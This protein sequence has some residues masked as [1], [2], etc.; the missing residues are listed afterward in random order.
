MPDFKKGNDGFEVKDS[1]NKRYLFKILSKIVTAPLTLIVQSIMPR[2]LGPEL[3][4]KYIFQTNIFQQVINFFD[5][6][7]SLAFYTGLSKNLNDKGIIRFYG[8]YT[9]FATLIVLILTSVI[10]LLNQ[11]QNVFPGQEVEYIFMAIFFTVITWWS[12]IIYKI[13]DAYGLT[14]NGEKILIYQKVVSVIFLIIIYHYDLITLTNIFI[15]NYI[16]LFILISW[17]TWCLHKNKVFIFKIPK[18]E[19][20]EKKNKLN[21]FW[22]YSSPLLVF[23]FLGMIVAFFDN[24]FLMKIA[25]PVQQGFFGL[26]FKLSS[27]SF[28]FTGAMTQL[29]TREFSIAHGNNDK[30]QLAIL[31][32]KYIPLLYLVTT[33]L[34][35]FF[36]VYAELLTKW[37][38]G[39]AFINGVL[40]I[41]IMLFYPIHQTYGQLSGSLFYS[42]GQTKLYRNIGIFMLPVGVVGTWITLAPS[43]NFGFHLGALGLALKTI[44][45]QFIAVNVQLYFN[46]KYLGLSFLKFFWHQ[47]YVL[48]TFLFFAFISKILLSLL[49]KS[50]IISFALSSIIYVLFVLI[51]LYL[52]PESISVTKAKRNDLI[53]NFQNLLINYKIK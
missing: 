17:W 49:I 24:W 23:S 13:I 53:N 15:Y 14:T 16:I 50:E 34:S 21:F 39:E 8:G 26:A 31:F 7:T 45:V 33:F 1:L 44:S 10:F 43:T 28:M 36:I 11:G 27:I 20:T 40:P 46:T 38:G 12:E 9:I 22:K 35:V 6:G 30:N 5:S 25:G 47:V 42:T 37:F 41:A 4:G 32:S 48:V 51:F 2:G 19:T 52:I 3:Y 29:I 18:L